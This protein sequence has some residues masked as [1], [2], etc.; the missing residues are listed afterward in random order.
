AREPLGA[1]H[2]TRPEHTLVR[3]RGLDVAER[4]DGSPE[5][6]DVRHRPAPQLVVA[7]RLDAACLGEP[8]SVP[9]DRGTLDARLAGPPQNRWRVAHGVK[10]MRGP[11]MV[12]EALAAPKGDAFRDVPRPQGGDPAND[13]RDVPV[14]RAGV[15]SAGFRSCGI[16]L[17]NDLRD[18]PARRAG[19]R[20]GG[21]RS[22]GI[23]PA[24]KVSAAGR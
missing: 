15:R 14:R 13:L 2:R 7:I 9:G 4:P 11:S 1:G 20:A 23:L 22:W 18:V 21:F 6:L 16:L 3:L 19:V 12:N 10:P 24:N 5:P 17:A 8:A